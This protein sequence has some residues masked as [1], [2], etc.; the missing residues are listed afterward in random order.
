MS[1]NRV[2]DKEDPD[3]IQKI[4]K[5]YTY[6]HIMEYYSAIKKNKIVPFAAAWMDLEIVI[7]T[8]RSKSDRGKQISYDIAFMWNLKKGYK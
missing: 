8:I 3:F 5:I 7:L 1:I 4:K 6:I 2:M